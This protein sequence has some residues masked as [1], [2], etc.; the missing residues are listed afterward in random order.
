VTPAARLEGVEVVRSGR[1]ILGPVDLVVARGGHLAVLGPNGSGKTTLLRL[2]ST[3]AHPTRGR[4]EVLGGRFGRVD[5][6][7]LRGRVAVVSAGMAG[8]LHGVGSAGELVAAARHGATRPV[9][10]IGPDDLAAADRA[11]ARVGADHLATRICRTLSQGEWQRVQVARALVTDPELLLLDEPF[12][13]LDL[14]ARESLLADVTTLMGE[15]DGPTVV[16]VTHHVE[17]VPD[18]IRAAL[19]LRE[20]RV[21]ASGDAAAV[22]TSARVSATFDVDVA[23]DHDRGRWRARLVR[24]GD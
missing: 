16:L 8:L 21:V 10:A 14:G 18:E 23:V 15:V 24:P 17:E 1:T 5:L 19:L 4:V 22:L 11:L 9:P 13:G 3:Y 7:E 20:G 2:L 6:R 12:V